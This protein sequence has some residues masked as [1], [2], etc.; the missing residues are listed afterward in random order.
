MQN[1]E[2]A[3]NLFGEHNA[4]EI[5]RHR[6]RGERELLLRAGTQ[7]VGETLGIAAEENEFA[8]AAVAEVGHPTSELGRRELLARGVEQNLGGNGINLKFL[9]RD[10]GCFA[11]FAHS[12]DGV[13]RDAVN[14][15]VEQRA[16]FVMASLAEHDE[17]DLHFRMTGKTEI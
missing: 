10:R 17:A 16:N 6:Q 2:S 13:I 14:V 8:R 9:E 15:F 5:V 11:Q 12:D 3:I 7:L 1:R 4:G